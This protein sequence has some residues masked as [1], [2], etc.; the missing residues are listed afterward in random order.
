MVRELMNPSFG[1]FTDLGDLEQGGSV[2]TRGMLWFNPDSYEAPVNFELVG[3]LLGLAIYNSV[4]L[5]VQFPLVLYKK[6]KG[7]YG[8]YTLSLKDLDD[9][10]PEV[11][12]NLKMML[13][14]KGDDFEDVF[15]LDFT[16]TR[17][18]TWGEVKTEDLVPNGATISVTKANRKEYVHAYLKWLLVTSISKQFNA[19]AR[20]FNNV[21]SGPA[22][23]MFGPS[24]LALLVTGSKK[25]DFEALQKGTHYEAPFH[26]EHRVIKWLWETVHGM[27]E[28]Q[29]KKFLSFV[30]GSDRS[31]IRGLQDIRMVVQRAGPDCDNLPTAST[32]FNTLLLYDNKDKEKFR[33]KLLKAIEE[34]EGFGLK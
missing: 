23:E 10:K 21:C 22:L 24:E 25:L 19:F 16:V 30:T 2:E 4:I 29:K 9:F 27:D 28:T 33:S 1:M 8:D 11:A 17:T 18:S 20:G 3:S 32:C 26:A 7:G 31:P 5:D 6:L 12:R 13:E 15:S 14:Y 34:S